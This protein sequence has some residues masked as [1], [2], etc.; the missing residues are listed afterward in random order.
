MSVI[1]GV[2]KAAGAKVLTGTRPNPRVFPTTVRTLVLMALALLALVAF[3]AMLAAS[4]APSAEH[5]S[6]GSN[7]SKSGAAAPVSEPGA[8]PQMSDEEALDAYGKLPLSFIP[9]EG[10]TDKAVRYYAQ[11]AGYGFFF[12]PG[13]A[14]LSFAEGKGRG[15]AL[16]L[17]F[18]RADPDAT[19]T[20]QKRLSGEVNHLVGD[21]PAKWQQ[22]LPTH[23]ELLYGRL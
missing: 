5:L 21:D 20:A 23:A 11:G 12:T 3:A 8:V 13:G 10:Q 22:N 16:A 6:V 18:L 19:L 2:A 14:M 7:D 1:A 4:Q 17:D 15:H 9:N